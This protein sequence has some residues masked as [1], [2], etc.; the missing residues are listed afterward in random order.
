M[1]GNPSEESLEGLRNTKTADSST[2]CSGGS[3][4]QKISRRKNADTL[5]VSLCSPY[6][7]NGKFGHSRIAEVYRATR[8]YL[9]RWR[10][11]STRRL[12]IKGIPRGMQLCTRPFW[13]AGVAIQH[14]GRIH[15]SARDD[16]A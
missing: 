11:A 8:H 16:R 4:L 15:P 12:S 14:N 9:V 13:S 5:G 2:V 10:T 3:P 1:R 6:A 7:E